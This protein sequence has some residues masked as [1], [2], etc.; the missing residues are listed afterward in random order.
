LPAVE[1]EEDGET[2][3]SD[4]E[5]A[6]V[7]G[8][9]VQWLDHRGTTGQLV[10]HDLSRDGCEPGPPLGDHEQPR[11]ALRLAGDLQ[12]VVASIL[13]VVHGCGRWWGVQDTLLAVVAV[14][15]LLQEECGRGHRCSEIR[16]SEAEA[17]GARRLL[18]MVLGQ[19]AQ[20]LN[21]ARWKR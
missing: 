4:A 17:L 19:M 1:V 3:V 20:C 21:V 8:D 16:R 14:H 9:L 10:F 18:A 2:E 13:A 11:G 5:L 7:D 6:G 12:R 15:C